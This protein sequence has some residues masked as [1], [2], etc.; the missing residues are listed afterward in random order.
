[1]RRFWAFFPTFCLTI[2]GNSGIKEAVFGDPSL[3]EG[4][5]KS[6]RWDGALLT[7]EG[8]W[9][10]HLVQADVH[11]HGVARLLHRSNQQPVGVH[12]APPVE[13]HVGRR[14]GGLE[15]G[16][17]EID[18]LRADGPERGQ[19]AASFTLGA[20]VDGA[21]R[22]AAL[23][24]SGSRVAMRGPGE[25]FQALFARPFGP[26]AFSAFLAQRAAAP[27]PW[28]DEPAPQPGPIALEP[29]AAPVPPPRRA[30]GPFHAVV[31]GGFS[32]LAS[33]TGTR[34]AF[35]V[36]LGGMVRS[37]FAVEL[38][39]G[40]RDSTH[41][42]WWEPYPSVGYRTNPIPGT[43]VRVQ[44]IPVAVNL[45]LEPPR[46]TARP[47][48]ILGGGI[49]FSEATLD[50]G[51]FNAVL[52]AHEQVPFLHAGAGLAIDLGRRDFAGAEARYALTSSLHVFGGSVSGDGLSGAAFV[53]VRL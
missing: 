21:V 26:V 48:A 39:T 30:L 34:P 7:D 42:P 47:Y 29:V 52:R 2:A 13:R 18:R 19:V 32:N 45:R 6:H 9:S 33:S 53:G 46:A 44:Q 22:L 5:A 24:P 3:E 23:S 4:H 25:I 38:E 31:R 10:L 12:F 15:A 8:A 27:E 20:A 40:Y 35:A 43:E 51:D 49:A 28:I 14:P 50:P 17:L 41:A 1:M 11:A 37:W 16:R 36:A